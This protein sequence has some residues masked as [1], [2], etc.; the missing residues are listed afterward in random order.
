MGASSIRL[1]RPSL[2]VQGAMLV[3]LAAIAATLSIVLSQPWLGLTLAGDADT[4]AVRI[5]AVD[6]SGPARIMTAPAT[7][8][9]VASPDD[10]ALAVTLETIDVI[11]E[12]DVLDTYAQ[13]DRL[14]ARQSALATLLRRP[15][16]ALNL[17]PAGSDES[18]IVSPART[19]VGALP[20][21]FWVQLLTGAASLLI[22]AWVWAMRPSDIATRL[23]AFSGA[24]I[25]L[26]AY[27]AAIY[28]SREIA[29][30]GGLFRLLSTLNHIGTIGFGIGM[31]TMFL[32]Y[33]RRL[34]PARA[35]W[36]APAIL[37]PWLAADIL[38]LAPNPPV[39]MQLPVM[40]AMLAIVGIVGIQ[41]RTNRRDPRARA[42]LGWLG[43]S[44]I[45]GAGA[46]V[47][48][49]V[50]PILLA[51]APMMQQG[52]AF[53]FFL[54][55][56]AGLALGVS[57]YRLFDLSEWAFRILFYTGGTLLLIAIDAA[58]LTFLHLQHAV[59]FGIALIAIGFAYLPLRGA[60]WDRFVVRKGLEEHELFR[61]VIDV[62]FASSPAERSE[63]WRDL[64]QTL[65]DPL[66]L[67]PADQQ[68]ADVRLRDEGLEMHLPP[69]ADTPAL[70]LRYPWRGRRLFGTAHRNLARELVRLM[71]YTEESRNA[72]ERGSVEERRRIA[73]DLHDDVGARLLSGLYKSDIGDTHRV[74][75]DAIADIRT[76]VS[77]LS[78]E[79][80][81]LGQ[82]IAALRHESGER[83]A[84]AGI[85]MHWPLGAD[86]DSPLA[87]DYRIYRCF[88]SAH[89][90]IVSNAIRHAG[91][92]RV[93]IRVL[94]A[95]DR[96]VTTIMDDGV[97]IDPAHT[98]GS[99]HGNGLR[100]LI[101]RLNELD[102]ML[103]V[104]R[105]ER[106]TIVEIHI[107]LKAATPGAK[108]GSEPDDTVPTFEGY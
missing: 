92:T 60:L 2:V 49:I 34:V 36:I 14:M 63:R 108:P 16:V 1:T 33:P 44:V 79:Q 74:L 19:P 6:P 45:V 98:A 12:P 9:A 87:L 59:S 69:A 65:F 95:E 31:I 11:E 64:L 77:G 58:L 100:G 52:Y 76:I 104:R 91:A 57:R 70:V 67:E 3:C 84:A 99:A 82:M 43:L 55:I 4:N 18:V 88:A 38:H 32:C 42:A 25:T 51:S 46:F 24:M 41:W 39:G 102:G 106:G 94:R 8:R 97:G 26:A 5:V 47:A 15:Q 72:Y 54:L 86:D 93:E 29:I 80:P 40:I 101:R 62:S 73:R 27:P 17:G 37:V 89:R 50:G 56:Y 22:G 7:L 10:S 53:G 13:I 78:T 30:D 21:A 71:R 105:G 61:A 103:S 83:L 85:E 96:L 107:P 81:L 48:L 28:S 23:F 20:A 75:R 68:A 90:E 66:A 35:L